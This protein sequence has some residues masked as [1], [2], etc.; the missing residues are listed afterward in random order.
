MVLEE[1][2]ALHVLCAGCDIVAV[3]ATAPGPALRVYRN[4]APRDS[5]A[6]VPR[7][8]G[9]RAIEPAVAWNGGGRNDGRALV[10]WSAAAYLGPE[11]EMVVAA[12]L[13]CGITTETAWFAGGRHPFAAPSSPI[14]VLGPNG[15]LLRWRL[16]FNMGS[17][18]AVV[19]SDGALVAATLDPDFDA[20]GAPDLPLDA[21]ALPAG[22]Y[23]VLTAGSDF[24]K[25]PVRAVATILADAGT[26]ASIRVL[27]PLDDPPA[28]WVRCDG[29][30]RAH[31]SGARRGM[32]AMPVSRRRPDTGECPPQAAAAV[33][34]RRVAH[35]LIS[36]TI[37][38][39]WRTI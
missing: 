27:G 7:A 26:P 33:A 31:F 21:C 3:L 9:A 22:G 25:A 8:I 5:I 37:A 20:D 16:E 23:A 35:P 12:V 15:A 14:A 30:G 38:N 34:V 18:I 13:P 6:I 32:R 1:Q 2:T 4:H 17:G 36:S 11:R 19:D 39:A 29:R 24:R 10:A 28:G